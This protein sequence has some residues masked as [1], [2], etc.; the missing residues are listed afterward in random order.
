MTTAVLGLTTEEKVKLEEVRNYQKAS[1]MWVATFQR[2]PYTLMTMAYGGENIDQLVERTRMVAG[3]HVYS[4]T[5]N[6]EIQIESIDYDADEVKYEYDGEKY[7]ESI[8][9]FEQNR[10]SWL[11]QW[12]TMWMIDE[13]LD[14]EWIEEN[15]DIVSEI[16]FRIFED[17]E[18]GYIFIGLDA[19]GCDFYELFWTPLYKARGLQWHLNEG[20][21]NR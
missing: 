20:L 5:Q 21:M 4:Y 14:S 19:G 3:E 9:D 1:E 15:L 7:C 8:H 10:D 17:E 6:A 12:G 16:G 13:S 11:P 2:M 18:N